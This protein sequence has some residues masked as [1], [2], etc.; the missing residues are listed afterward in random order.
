MHGYTILPVSDFGCV[1]MKKE[2]T[3][4]QMLHACFKI[5]VFFT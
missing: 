4:K 1:Y 2:K 5:F 3:F